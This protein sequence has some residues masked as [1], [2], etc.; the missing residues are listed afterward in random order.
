LSKEVPL[1]RFFISSSIGMEDAV[2]SEIH[3]VW[4]ELLDLDG[5]PHCEQ[6]VDLVVEKGGVSLSAPLHLGLQLNFFLKV[7][8]RIL[9]RLKEF[10][11]RDFPKL[12]AEAQ[13]IPLKEYVE[14]N[15]WN[16]EVAASKSR[17]NHEGRV[18]DTLKKAFGLLEHDSTVPV[19]GSVYARFYDDTCSL[20]LDTSGEHL[21]FR[22]GNVHKGEAPLR[23][24]IAAFCLRLMTEGLSL[25]ELSQIQWYDP[26]VGSGTFLSEISQRFSINAHRT[27]AFQSW[28]KTPKAL[29]GT[30]WFMNYPNF[31]VD[32]AGQFLLYGSDID[33]Q[34][35]LLCQEN[36]KRLQ[37]D[38]A[39]TESHFFVHDIL[40]AEKLGEMSESKPLWMITNPPYGERIEAQFSPQ[41]LLNA[42]T[43]KFQ[44]ERLGILFSR[45]QR[46]ELRTLP[47]GY[48]LLSEK[49]VLNGGIPCQ[50]VVWTRAQK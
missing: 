5:R 30:T 31:K 37:V 9:L 27:Y 46:Q 41:Q 47:A 26:M 4:G 43:K 19:A 50:F 49:S 39:N 18:R 22:G 25:V 8:H 44:P 14:S 21:H 32:K 2:A 35:V 12:F 3:E 17:L 20:S 29:R 11:C 36:L 45:K 38:Q 15:H 40:S 42:I 16:L 13:K 28:K 7:P 33:P 48:S 6:I 1:Q 34:M 10:R 23:E 24:T